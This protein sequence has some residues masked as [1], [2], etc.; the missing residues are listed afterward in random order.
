MVLV[1]IRYRRRIDIQLACNTPWSGLVWGMAGHATL[2]RTRFRTKQTSVSSV[3]YAK[4]SNGE[5]S[6]VNYHPIR[7]T[8]TGN[9]YNVSSAIV[10]KCTA[11]VNH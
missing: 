5:A 8:P 11:T 9:R 2:T 10:N 1:L 3:K 7:V 4:L 6:K